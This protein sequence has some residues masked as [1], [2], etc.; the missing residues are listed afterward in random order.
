MYKLTILV[1]GVVVLERVLKR[2]HISPM[3][4]NFMQE[5]W[6]GCIIQYEYVGYKK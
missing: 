4:N 3:M 1:D 5:L 2:K 6:P